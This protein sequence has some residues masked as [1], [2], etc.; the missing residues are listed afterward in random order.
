MVAIKESSEK[1]EEVAEG[2]TKVSDLTLELKEIV[3]QNEKESTE[4]L[5]IAKESMEKLSVTH[6]TSKEIDQQISSLS[7]AAE[8]IGQITDAIKTISDQTNLLALNA[9]IEAARAGEA[10]KGFAVVAEEIRKLAEESTRFAND[11]VEIIS[12]IQD[13]VSHTSKS[14][15]VIME[16]LNETVNHMKI[17]FNFKTC[18]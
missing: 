6:S 7:D 14:F 13:D 18:I 12:R 4:G 8:N 10:G 1:T 3:S 15:G 9:A 17:S 16:E 11:I 5:T 2:S